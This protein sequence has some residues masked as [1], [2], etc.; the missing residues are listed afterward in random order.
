M[1][2]ANL[3]YWKSL[4]KLNRRTAWWHGELQDYNFEIVHTPGKVHMAADALS[5]P[6]GADEGKDDNQE[7]TM[8]PESTFIR[9]TDEDSPGSI[10]HRIVEAQIQNKSTMTSWEKQGLIYATPTINGNMWKDTKQHH[11]AI[12]P[13]PQIQREVLRFWHDGPTRGHPGRDET[14]RKITQHYFW[15]GART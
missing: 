15:P 11:L 8:I 12:P 7:I 6:P 4:R 3:L 10:E 9:V 1:D 2:H 5:R 13:N 14:T